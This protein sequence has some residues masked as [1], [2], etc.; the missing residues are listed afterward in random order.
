M[1]TYIREKLL[2]TIQVSI[3]RIKNASIGITASVTKK[4]I[5][6]IRSVRDNGV[7]R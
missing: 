5:K 7:N 2:I 6:I 1:K 4:S 3:K